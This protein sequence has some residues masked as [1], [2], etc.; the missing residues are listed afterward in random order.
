MMYNHKMLCVFAMPIQKQE[1]NKKRTKFF[2]S[3]LIFPNLKT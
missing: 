2:L 3:P 1:N